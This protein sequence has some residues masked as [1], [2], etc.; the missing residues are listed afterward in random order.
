M[1]SVESTFADSPRHVSALKFCFFAV[2]PGVSGKLQCL[3]PVG[4]SISSFYLE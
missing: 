3:S 2:Y 4:S 1:V